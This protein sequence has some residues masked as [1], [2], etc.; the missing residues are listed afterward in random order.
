MKRITLVRPTA[1]TTQTP[2]RDSV[3]ERI[4]RVTWMQMSGAQAQSIVGA[5]TDR[6]Y[7]VRFRRPARMSRKITTAWTVR[8]QAGDV[9]QI[10]SATENDGLIS[11]MVELV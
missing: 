8:D 9:Y 10:R 3:D 1:T 11:L 4:V 7:N 2:E 5:Y 6:L